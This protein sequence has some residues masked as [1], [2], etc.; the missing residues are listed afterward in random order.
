MSPAASP[1]IL[2]QQRQHG[3]LVTGNRPEVRNA[4]D[5]AASTLLGG[6]AV[7]RAEHQPSWRVLVLTGAGEQYFCAGMDLKAA[8]GGEPPAEAGS[9]RSTAE[10]NDRNE[11]RARCD[12]TRERQLWESLLHAADLVP[13][14]VKRIL[15]KASVIDHGSR[16]ELEQARLLSHLARH[17]IDTQGN[18]A[19]KDLVAIAKVAVPRAATSVID[20]AIQVHGGAGVTGA[21]PLPAMC[22]RH[23]AMRLFDGP[24][25]VHARTIAKSEL[26]RTWALP[27]STGST[28]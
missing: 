1:K 22:G 2:I 8:A 3:L 24:D 14:S 5:A 26:R 16:L 9:V 13:D 17:V 20:R 4:L 11:H 28:A 21:M 6:E 27:L 15:H 18:R 19:A 7:Q 10:R 12:S 23:R 25:G